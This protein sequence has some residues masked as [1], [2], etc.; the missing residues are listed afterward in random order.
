MYDAKVLKG[1][2]IYLQYPSCLVTTVLFNTVYEKGS[3]T[4]RAI[5][6]CF[7]KTSVSLKSFLF[8]NLPETMQLCKSLFQT[9]SNQMPNKNGSHQ[10]GDEIRRKSLL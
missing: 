2:T 6:K 3:R 1:L 5:L 10:Q 9:N 4:K 7:N 8:T